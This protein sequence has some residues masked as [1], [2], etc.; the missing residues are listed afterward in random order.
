MDNFLEVGWGWW[1]CC[2]FRFVVVCLENQC[3][4]NINTF[5]CG[6]IVIKKFHNVPYN[7][8]LNLKNQNYLNLLRIMNF[9]HYL[10]K[11]EPT[12]PF[13]AKWEDKYC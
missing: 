9:S 6:F 11:L 7:S 5:H 1:F 2:L 10:M 8:I 4:V 3:N 13:H 12:S